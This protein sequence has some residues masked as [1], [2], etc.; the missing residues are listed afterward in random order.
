MSNLHWGYNI[1]TAA[2]KPRG[3]AAGVLRIA[4]RST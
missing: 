2:W 1:A 4:E 3:I